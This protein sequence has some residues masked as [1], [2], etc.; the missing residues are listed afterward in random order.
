VRLVK[1]STSVGR[2]WMSVNRKLPMAVASFHRRHS[3][4]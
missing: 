4:P 3:I 1:S 2:L